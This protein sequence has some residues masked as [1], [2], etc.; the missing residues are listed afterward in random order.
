MPSG[1]YERRPRDPATRFW[2]KVRK[3][4]ECWLWSAGT[5]QYGY[6]LFW[7]RTGMVSAHRFAYELERGQ[8]PPGHELDHRPS[9]PK[10]CVRP[11][12]LRPASRKQNQ[13]NLAGP[14]RNG[15][16]GVRGVSWFKRDGKWRGQVKH[17]GRV[18]H[19]GYFDSLAEAE[20]AVIAKRNELFTHNDLDR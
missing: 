11:D 2:E 17:H 1:V 18:F 12:H 14:H 3:T 20:A 9:C 16:S 6:G 7:Y 15:T 10:H 4:D 8:I 5:N 19:V 13:E